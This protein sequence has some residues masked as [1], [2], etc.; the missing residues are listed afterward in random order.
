MYAAA[1]SNG[2]CLNDYINS[3]PDLLK[4]LID[5]LLNFRVGRVAVCGD[6]AERY[7]RPKVPVVGQR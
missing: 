3:G 5:V 4:S 6:V 7:A 1:K 2:V